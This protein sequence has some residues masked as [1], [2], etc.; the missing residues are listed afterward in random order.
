[1]FSKIKNDG[2]FHNPTLSP[3]IIWCKVQALFFLCVDGKLTSKQFEDFTTIISKSPATIVLRDFIIK[4]DG[5]FTI[6]T[7]SA[8][9]NYLICHSVRVSLAA[10]NPLLHAEC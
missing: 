8:Q 4:C 1:M 7:S 10:S 6:N 5:S 2:L 9:I 3:N